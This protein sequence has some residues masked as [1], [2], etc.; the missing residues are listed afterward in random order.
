M[1]VGVVSVESS[2]SAP[3]KRAPERPSRYRADLQGLR[4]V[5]SL[6][7]VTYHTWVG[8]VSGGVDIFFV[9]T[10][11]LI[12]TTLLG[13]LE[14]T[15]RVDVRGFVG[16]LAGRLLPLAGIVLAL[17][18]I[19][20]LVAWPVFRWEGTFQQVFASATYWENWL[21][22][23]LSTDYL[24]QGAD[25]SPV[26]HFWAMSVQG[27]FYLIWAGLFVLVALLARTFSGRSPRRIAFA[28]V[29]AVTLASSC[30]AVYGIITDPVF[31]YFDTFARLWEFG[32]GALVAIVA[33]RL[34]LPRAVRVGL[35]VAGL[36]LILSAGLL[37]AAWHYP[38]LVALW[39]A[40][41][42]VALLLSHRA[43]DDRPGP[44]TRLLAWRPLS[45][46]GNYSYGLYL[47]GWPV[48]VAYHTLFPGTAEVGPVA[49]TVVIVVSLVLAVVTIRGLKLFEALFARHRPP[50]LR[51]V[52]PF[53]GLVPLIAI[54]SLLAP[55][56][57]TP[58]PTDQRQVSAAADDVDQ[59]SPIVEYDNV[60]QLQTDIRSAL[61]SEQLPDELDPGFGDASRVPE[62]I[63]DEC[64]T[65]DASNVD[66]CRYSDGDG[67]QGEIVV[68][69]D[70]QAVSWM[71]GLRAAVDG[72]ASI[73]LLT[74]EMCPVSTVPVSSAWQGI[75]AQQACLEHNEWTMNE[76]RERQPLLVV[77]SFGV[78]RSARV[79]DV[80]DAAAGID[81]LVAGTRPYLAELQAL[82]QPTVWLD[83]PPPGVPRDECALART[84]EQYDESCIRS[85]DQEGVWRIQGLAGAAAEYGIP[86]ESTTSWFCDTQSG[87][88]PAYVRDIAVQ[89]DGSHLTWGMSRALAPMIDSALELELVLTP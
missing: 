49:G 61:A 10:G 77:M 24:A 88:C 62:W 35:G 7:V 9:V 22:A 42:A 41:G 31:T 19:G 36:A 26:Q 82:G 2:R 48:L 55:M 3:P 67:A 20:V 72:R 56:T 43:G 33:D 45:T 73:Q 14:R 74:R 12:T 60:E 21:L 58:A 8:T 25:K 11:M 68:I 86:F 76:I 16:R 81:E 28:V 18:S 71:P 27:Q 64:A 54:A 85:V 66:R 32:L 39:P 79:Q 29:G 40:G 13:G 83:S 1:R 5:A 38:G 70:S 57:T 37:P 84:A 87:F 34:A 65:V 44:V 51:T 52:S 15:G 80:D 89:A 50:A 63:D 53:A 23:D 4:A 46:L 6:L 69:G 78:W 47:F 59:P 30:W 75:D 17:V